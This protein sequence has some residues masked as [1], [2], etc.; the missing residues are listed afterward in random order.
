MWSVL[1]DL[2]DTSLRVTLSRISVFR[3][4]NITEFFILEVFTGI[5]QSHEIIH[6]IGRTCSDVK[7]ND[8]LYANTM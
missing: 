4:V 5:H 7:V 2:R 8:V 1:I 6:I 3:T